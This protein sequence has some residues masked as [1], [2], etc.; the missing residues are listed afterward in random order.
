MGFVM[1]V[2]DDIEVQADI[3]LGGM[4]GDDRSVL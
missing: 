2:L 4:D 1:V 3:L